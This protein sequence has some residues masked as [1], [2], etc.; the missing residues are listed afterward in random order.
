MTD[1]PRACA[2]FAAE[3]RSLREDTGLSLV[4]LAE[5]TP[6]SKSSWQRYLSGAA[7]PPW[8][9]VQAL[10]RL[11]ERPQD[12]WRAQW[13][14]AEAAWSG[15]NVL[16]RQDPRVT[17]QPVEDT[18]VPPR[19]VQDPE[20]ALGPPAAGEPVVPRKRHVR[21]PLLALVAGVLLAAGAAVAVLLFPGGQRTV[22]VSK[23]LPTFQVGCTGSACTGEDPTPTLC[24][25]EPRTLMNRQLA[26]GVGLEVRY[27]P[28]CRAAWA[29][30]WNTHVG[31]ALTLSAPREAPQHVAVRDRADTDAF[32]YTPMLA[33][34][35]AGG[36]LRVCVTPAGGHAECFSVP[37]P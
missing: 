3:L 25:V 32:L 27:N 9:A 36:A 35:S 16:E 6:Y 34:P 19:P 21:R 1:I 18:E 30:F 33:V 5:R 23:G 12:R 22:A 37:A 8:S 24:G 10:C 4:A 2:R 7:L 13:E 17:P 26:D 31:D 14:L 11:A 29:R 20:D 15:R 28:L